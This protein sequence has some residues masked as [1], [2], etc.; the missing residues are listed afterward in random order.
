M[1]VAHRLMARMKVSPVPGVWLVEHPFDSRSRIA[2][3]MLRGC[4]LL[5]GWIGVV[6]AAHLIGRPPGCPEFPSHLPS[7]HCWSAFLF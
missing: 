1:V 4:R 7:L 2:A 3:I 6:T 5:A